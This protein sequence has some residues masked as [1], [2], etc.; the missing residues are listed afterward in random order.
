[1]PSSGAESGRNFAT[2]LQALK[3]IAKPEDLAAAVA[4]LASD[5]ARWIAGASIPVDGDSKLGVGQNP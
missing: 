1:L 4:F 3:R 2:G 5:D